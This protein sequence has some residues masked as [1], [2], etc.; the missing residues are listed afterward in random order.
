MTKTKNVKKNWAVVLVLYVGNGEPYKEVKKKM[1]LEEAY[2]L[3]A[4]HILK[5]TEKGFVHTAVQANAKD[6][7]KGKVGSWGQKIEDHRHSLHMVNKDRMV[8]RIAVK[9]IKKKKGKT[10]R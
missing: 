10:K 7:K 1:G 4:K 9:R 3:A 5:L 2:M 6:K 8:A